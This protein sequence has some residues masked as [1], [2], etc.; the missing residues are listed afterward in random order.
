MQL[1]FFHFLNFACKPG[2]QCH[3]IWTVHRL[4]LLCSRPFRVY[5][6]G[7]KKETRKIFFLFFFLFLPLDS[8]F[9]LFKLRVASCYYSQGYWFFFCFYFSAAVVFSVIRLFSTRF[10]F[11]FN[12]WLFE[13]TISIVTIQVHEILWNSAEG[14]CCI[15]CCVLVYCMKSHGDE[16]PRA[17]QS[18]RSVMPCNCQRIFDASNQL[19][20]RSRTLLGF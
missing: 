2:R 7:G 11:F 3:S 17:Y 13:R 20:N 16:W 12:I 1:A 19:G 9:L 15:Q 14:H 4:F 18:C 8:V 5:Y 6:G 10:C